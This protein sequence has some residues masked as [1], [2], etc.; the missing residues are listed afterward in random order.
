[1][2]LE[3]IRQKGV[4][5]HLAI[6]L[7]GNGRWAKRRGMPRAYGHKVGADNIIKAAQL[8]DKLGIKYLT[9]YAFSTE[10][11]SRPEQE[12]NYLMELP[13]ELYEEHK[14]DILSDNHNL[15]LKHVGR[16]DR[17][18]NKLKKLFA[19][20][21]A[22]TKHH[23]GLV[24]QLAFDYGFYDELDQAIKKM[25]KDNKTSF[26]K[27]EI[28]PYLYVNEPVDFLIRTSG[29]KR[30]SNFLLYQV[31]YAEFYFTKKHWPAFNE[32][33]FLKAIKQFQKRERRYGG[34]K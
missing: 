4:P 20:L 33:T 11:W 23:T 9:V 16:N 25:I 26:S 27:E 10:N 14:E 24:L 17:L 15:V 13:F 8:A 19:E 29:E 12:V 5:R 1:M 18:P 3:K 22:K 2:K 34:L 31:G 6:I 30:L 32:R 21:Y 7:D 28:L